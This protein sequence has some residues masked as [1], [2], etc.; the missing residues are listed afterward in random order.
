METTVFLV[1][2]G[3]SVENSKGIFSGRKDSGLTEKGVKQAKNLAAYFSKK[4][5][6]ALYT[7]SVNR[8]VK[9]AEIIG[10]KLGLLPIKC[11]ELN[12]IKGGDLEGMPSFLA[13]LKCVKLYIG[14]ILS[15]INLKGLRPKGGENFY[16]LRTRMINAL[17]KIVNKH[18]GKNIVVVSHSGPLKEFL[19]SL[20]RKK[21]NIFNYY[22]F[23]LHNG[24]VSIIKYDFD[25][26]KFSILCIDKKVC[27]LS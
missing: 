5:I 22:G 24:R 15:G 6:A 18:K 12:E 27:L 26:R 25:K 2:H 21:V 13:V 1:R 16:E 17:Y 8:A 11:N 23:L 7:S 10:N 9:T 20:L 14:G 3:E 4:S 19:G